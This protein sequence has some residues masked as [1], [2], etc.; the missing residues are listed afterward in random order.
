MVT[1]DILRQDLTA[2]LRAMR[3]RHAERQQ[4]H[5]L[6]QQDVQQ[7]AAIAAE[8][9]EAAAAAA[10][11]SSPAGGGVAAGPEAA[12]ADAAEA[13]GVGVGPAVR[14]VANLPYYITKD[15][16]LLMLP[17]GQHISHLYFMLQVRCCV[18]R[19]GVVYL[20]FSSHSV[21]CTCWLRG[22]GALPC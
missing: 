12:S 9:A 20:A 14:V 2:L 10:A 21:T 13:A 16:L 7:P 4:Q 19:G 17:L 6:E 8:S 15:C 11:A 18:W 5:E 3:L 1:G 22:I